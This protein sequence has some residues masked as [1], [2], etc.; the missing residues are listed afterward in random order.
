MY[1]NLQ[2]YSLKSMYLA[3]EFYLRISGRTVETK[4]LL[5][6]YALKMMI[7]LILKCHVTKYIKN[8]ILE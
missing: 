1:S 7:Y 8:N 3:N 6:T 2:I 5:P 4:Q